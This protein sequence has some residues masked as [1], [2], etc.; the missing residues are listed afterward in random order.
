M[1]VANT[2]VTTVLETNRPALLEG[3]SYNI[4]SNVIY[5]SRAQPCLLHAVESPQHERPSRAP[6]PTQAAKL[7]PV[8]F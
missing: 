8:G 5:Q 7:D 1:T 4:N 3:S 6:T 2:E